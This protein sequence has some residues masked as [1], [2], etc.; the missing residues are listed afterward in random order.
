MKKIRK[1]LE[2]VALNNFFL[3]W[4]YLSFDDMI[5]AENSNKNHKYEI[6]P[7]NICNISWVLFVILNMNKENYKKS[8]YYK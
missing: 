3:S 5:S 2:I 8:K 6:D 4:E 1:I 7:G